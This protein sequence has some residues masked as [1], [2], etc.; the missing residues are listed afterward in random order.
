MKSAV[1]GNRGGILGGEDPRQAGLSGTPPMIVLSAQC[2]AEGLIRILHLSL[3]AHGQHQ[4]LRCHNLVLPRPKTIHFPLL[5]HL[6]I[7][8]RLNRYLPVILIRLRLLRHNLIL[9]LRR[10]T[11]LPVTYVATTSVAFLLLLLLPLLA[12]IRVLP[13]VIPTCI[14][15]S[16]HTNNNTNSHIASPQF[17]GVS[18]LYLVIRTT[19]YRNQHPLNTG[20]GRET[21]WRVSDTM[22]THSLP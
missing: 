15:S 12:H 6:S 16:N 20:I 18:L 14:S 21:K 8:T 13:A 7:R 2:R 19:G 3:K 22:A 1:A 10:N 17:L 4:H 9:T 5:I 11:V